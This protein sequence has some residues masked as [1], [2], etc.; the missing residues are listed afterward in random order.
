MEPDTVLS[1]EKNRISFPKNISKNDTSKVT[2]N[3]THDS[4]SQPDVLYYLTEYNWKKKKKEEKTCSAST[5]G[6]DLVAFLPSPVLPCA[7]TGQA[8]PSERDVPRELNPFHFG[9]KN[10]KKN[11]RRKGVR[12]IQKNAKKRGAKKIHHRHTSSTCEE[13]VKSRPITNPRY[14]NC[15]DHED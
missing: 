6:R 13:D 7:F 3:P 12:T 8:K 10:K 11:F 9:Y 4:R 2:N 1:C 14:V 5:K 15:T